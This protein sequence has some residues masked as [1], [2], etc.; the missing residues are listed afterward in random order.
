M[1]LHYLCR[2]IDFVVFS[3]PE[4]FSLM[5]NMMIKNVELFSEAY[6]ILGKKKSLSC[7][8]SLPWERAYGARQRVV[9][10]VNTKCQH[11]KS[12]NTSS[13]QCIFIL[14]TCVFLTFCGP[15]PGQTTKSSLEAL[16]IP[17]TDC[18]KKIHHVCLLIG[19]FPLTTWLNY[20]YTLE[21]V[22]E[23]IKLHISL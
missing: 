17:S 4:C 2:S 23:P 14:S 12:S 6:H 20:I 19:S 13:T 18:W 10:P 9:L 1:F 15:R 5:F 16:M 21:V 11:V 3:P 22:H 7:L 8:L